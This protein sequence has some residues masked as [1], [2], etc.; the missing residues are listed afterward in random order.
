VK[1][2]EFIFDEYKKVPLYKIQIRKL[3]NKTIECDN[4]VLRIFQELKKM[5]FRCFKNF[6]LEVLVVQYKKNLMNNL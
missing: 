4:L 2:R 1:A 5:L 3:K 6:E